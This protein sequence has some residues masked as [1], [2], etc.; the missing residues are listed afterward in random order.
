M[1]CC[2][3]FQQDGRVL[4]G[5]FSQKNRISTIHMPLEA[6]QWRELKSK[7]PGINKNLNDLSF[8]EESVTDPKHATDT[9]H[10]EKEI[11]SKIM[12]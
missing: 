9:N 6:E 10:E 11:I 1:Q 4:W 2:S 5:V 8:L 7:L 3:H 12:T